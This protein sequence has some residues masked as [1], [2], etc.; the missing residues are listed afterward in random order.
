MHNR[1]RPREG[2]YVEHSVFQDEAGTPDAHRCPEHDENTQ[3]CHG[4]F[5]DSLREE[6]DQDEEDAECKDIG[7]SLYEDRSPI[8]KDQ[9]A[10]D[11]RFTGKIH[12]QEEI[13]GV[14]P[15]A[16]EEVVLD[17][18]GDGNLAV[19]EGAALGANAQARHVRLHRARARVAVA[20]DIGVVC[21]QVSEHELKGRVLVFERCAALHEA[22]IDKH[23]VEGPPC[24][25]ALNDIGAVQTVHAVGANH[26][27][28]VVPDL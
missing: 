20:D 17:I 28:L 21:P 8:G 14:L 22:E 23:A 7:N 24:Q 16:V 5:W 11:G 19:A 3:R 12:A 25:H 18:S 6:G 9:G 26:R 2:A 15:G 1:N 10:P 13:K 4:R 27:R